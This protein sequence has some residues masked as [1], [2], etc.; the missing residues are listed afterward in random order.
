M[1]KVVPFLFCLLALCLAPFLRGVQADEVVDNTTCK[2]LSDSDE[3]SDFNSLRRKVVEGFNRGEDRSCT[4]LIVLGPGRE[5]IVHLKSTLEIDNPNDVDCPAGPDKPAVCGDGWGLILDGSPSTSF[6]LDARGL[7]EGCALRLKANRVLLKGFKILVNPGTQAI[8]DEGQS[9]DSTGVE[10]N[11]DQPPRPSPS[12]SPAP[13]QP[14]PS[15]RPVLTPVP[16]ATPEATPAAT[17]IA[18]P[19][20]TPLATPS[21]SPSP[22]PQASPIP[23]ATPNPEDGDHDGI[24]NATDN[25][26]N[27]AN[28]D[29][30]DS[31]HDGIG[32]AC[33]DDFSL[34]PDDDDGDGVLNENDNCG[35]VANPDQADADHDGIGDA[36]DTEIAVDIP[37]RFPGFQP[38]A[39]SCSLRP[40][41]NPGASLLWLLLWGLP[42]LWRFSCR[43]TSSPPPPSSS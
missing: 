26:P 13:V 31:D 41:K 2:V 37:D 6:T 3:L 29:Q 28:L 18:T 35:N 38:G 17:P 30:L 42:V 25:C 39:A 24:P 43:K 1:S 9:N 36:C 10:T 12:P 11:T 16:L 22:T 27:A 20:A 40:W 21:A 15:P 23:P 7:Q 5:T 19:V 32:D 33:D 14:S 34:A 4:E 8:C